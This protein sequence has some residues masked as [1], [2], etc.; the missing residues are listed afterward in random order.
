MTEDELKKWFE[1]PYETDNQIIQL[2]KKMQSKW[3]D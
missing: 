1:K 3:E 2:I